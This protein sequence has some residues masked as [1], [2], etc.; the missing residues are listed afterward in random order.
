VAVRQRSTPRDIGGLA[1]GVGKAAT[2]KR[3]EEEEEHEGEGGGVLSLSSAGGPP[4]IPDTEGMDGSRMST[5]FASSGL[6][7]PGPRWP[8]QIPPASWPRWQP[9]TKA[10]RGGSRVCATKFI[11][12][13]YFLRNK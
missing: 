7:A 5:S 11:N 3:R 4:A 10:V 6:L 9:K 1:E 12:C 8:S 13:G 2:K